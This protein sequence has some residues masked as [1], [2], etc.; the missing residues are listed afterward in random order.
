MNRI[1]FAAALGVAALLLS[2]AALL[3]QTPPA[4]TPPPPAHHPLSGFMARLHA[5]HPGHSAPAPPHQNQHIN[6]AAAA[7]GSTR[8]AGMPGVAGQ[9][10]G[11]KKS[12]VYHL[13]GSK[14]TLPAPQNRVYFASAAQAQAAG[15]RQAGLPGAHG[16]YKPARTS[17]HPA[18][19][20]TAHPGASGVPAH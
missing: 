6:P 2:P 10:I 3:A 13:P 9:I 11:D 12:H 18:N 15:F 7:P 8:M 17:R 1:R 16:T 4:S 19:L 14:G 20:G 5:M